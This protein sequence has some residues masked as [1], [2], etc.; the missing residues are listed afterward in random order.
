MKYFDYRQ[1]EFQGTNTVLIKDMELRIDMGS[2]PFLEEKFTVVDAK[3]RLYVL[4]IA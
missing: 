4:F 2:L 1:A 3:Y